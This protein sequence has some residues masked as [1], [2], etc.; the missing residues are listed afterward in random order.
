MSNEPK[1]FTA[2]RNI[3]RIDKQRIQYVSKRKKQSFL[4]ILH[5]NRDKAKHLM[6]NEAPNTWTVLNQ[7]LLLVLCDFFSPFI[8]VRLFR[9]SVKNYSP[10]DVPICTAEY[11]V[12]LTT[13]TTSLE[14][15]SKNIE[16]RKFLIARHCNSKVKFEKCIVPKWNVIRFSLSIDI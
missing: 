8:R 9:T 12:K 11:S 16:N 7:H 6:Q 15:A 5:W 13:Y 2:H 10:P 1:W 3:P 4:E 14:A